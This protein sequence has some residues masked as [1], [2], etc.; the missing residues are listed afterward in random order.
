MCLALLALGAPRFL[1][2]IGKVYD[3]VARIDPVTTN[4]PASTNVHHIFVRICRVA[5]KLK[6]R[7]MSEKLKTVKKIEEKSRNFAKFSR[8][9]KFLVL[10]KFDTSISH[11]R[12]FRILLKKMTW[13]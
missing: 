3:T 4:T 10:R 9:Y 11:L 5:I 13:Q 8:K 6:I 12:S 2:G 7:E 1:L